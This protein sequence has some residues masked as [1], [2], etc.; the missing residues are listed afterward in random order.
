MTTTEIKPA[1]SGIQLDS[2]QETIDAESSAEWATLGNQ[3][4]YLTPA[5]LLDECNLKFQQA[6]HPLNPLTIIDPQCG[7][8]ALL[9]YPSYSARRYGVD[10]DNRISN[11]NLY[12]RHIKGNCVKV[13]EALEDIY[14]DT[15][16]QMFN[17]NPPFGKRWK[18]AGGEV[19]DSTKW[20]WE[21]AVQF[22]NMGIFISNAKTIE[23]LGIDEH[24]WVFN[25]VTH[26]GS[27]LWSGM[28]DELVIG[29]VLWRR[30]STDMTYTPTWNM[31]SR[32]NELTKIAEEEQGVLPKYNIYLDGGGFLKTYL[33]TR[34][35]MSIEMRKKVKRD[36]ILRLHKINGAHPLTLTAEKETRDLMRDLAKSGIYDIEPAAMLAIDKALEE[37]KLMACP[38]MP[39]T[40]FESVAYADEEEE[41]KCIKDEESVA[42]MEPS[43]KSYKFT[44]GKSYKI[45]TETYNFSENFKGMKPH[46]DEGTMTTYVAEH[47]YLLSGQDRLLS[48]KDDLSRVIRFMDRPTK[49]ATDINESKLWSIFQRPAVK[50]IAEVSEVMVR[51]N[52][53]ILKSC[54]MLA[55]F[56][57]YQ[58]QIPYLARMG[59]KDSAYIAAATGTGKTLFALSLL[60]MKA[61]LRTL[62]VAPQGT[63]RS[64]D[65]EAGDVEDD[66]GIEYNASQWVSEIHRFA[67]YLQVWELFSHEDYERICSLNGGELPP[68]VYVSYYQAMFQNGAR[69]K[70]PDTW[71]DERLAAEVEKEFKLKF[72]LPVESANGNLIPTTHWCDSVGKEENGIRCIITPCLSTRIGHLFDC[73]MLDEAHI[74]THI[75]STVTQMVIR[76]QPKHRYALTATP[77]PNIITNLFAPMGWLCVKDW[78][79]GGNRNAAW[80]FAREDIA[81]FDAAFLSQVRDLTEEENKIK[82]DP[83]WRG[84]CTRKSP[85]ISSPARL[86]K[87]LKPTMA[88]IGKLDCNPEYTP[89][90]I[91]DI[92]VPLGK[93]QALLYHH[94]LNRGNI[95]GKHPLVRARKQ[96]AYLRAI[97]ADPEGFR[98]HTAA[99]SKFTVSSNFNPKVVTI[100]QLVAQVL[101]EGEQV[102]IINSRVGLNDT[103]QER[104]VE[105]GVSVARIDSTIL[106]A[107]HSDQSNLFKNGKARVMIM[108]IKCAAA[109]SFSQCK[110]EIIGSI[111]YSPGPFDQAKGRID[112]VNSRPG[113]TIYCILHKHSME[114][115]MFDTVCQK[116]DAATICL[117]GQRVPRLFKPVDAAEVL[118]KAITSFDL[119]GS[120]PESECETQWPELKTAIVSSVDFTRKNK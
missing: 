48:V 83:K 13:F 119:T 39:V 43:S 105:S 28:K 52:T 66:D 86:L 19:V 40:D 71:N 63:M 50:T 118:A 11:S 92:R 20:T 24:P 47:T 38:I 41:L 116:D 111:E 80:P 23:K 64:G 61:P 73:V 104:L 95:P 2:L 70:A 97:C 106:A 85:I 87:Y 33:S 22:G 77:I 44:A 76:M 45:S 74:I 37:V 5:W 89:P 81:R 68:G 8:A 115:I 117:R 60:A 78:Y 35:V 103:I 49:A 99:S 42:T 9:R 82:A 27:K 72:K 65:S 108:G 98:H 53:A 14:P 59:C 4:Q 21:K 114:E 96:G 29:V 112:R 102:V 12:I 62:I 75:E 31:D 57:Y 3:Q 90:N 56:K 17:A 100:L 120:K 101:A 54:E 18:T 88:Y 109:H 7:E 91:I 26:S 6:G 110:Y 94:F 46:F 113:V 25:Y 36:T 69:E 58:G 84:K 55:G 30:P 107:N 34:K 16:F 51:Q 79:R 32:W 10:I 15:R 93:E 1:R 67:P